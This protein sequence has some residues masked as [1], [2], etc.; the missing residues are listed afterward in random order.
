[1]YYSALCRI[2]IYYKGHYSA[3]CR[4]MFSFFMYHSAPCRMRSLFCINHSALCR[5]RVVCC[6]F[7]SAPCRIGFRAQH[8]CSALLPKVPH[9]THRG[10]S[11]NLSFMRMGGH[12]LQILLVYWI[13]IFIYFILLFWYIAI[14]LVSF[15]VFVFPN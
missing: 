6:K 11:N 14:I 10:F 13:V 5:I 9:N 15:L 7:R 4:I 3:L 2:W 8:T 12:S 1:M